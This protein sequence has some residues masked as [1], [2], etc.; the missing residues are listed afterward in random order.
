MQFRELLKRKGLLGKKLWIAEI[1]W[2]QR[3]LITACFQVLEK[4]FE[5]REW[6][7]TETIFN[8]LEKFVFVPFSW[9]SYLLFLLYEP[10]NFLVCQS[11]PGKLSKELVVS[12]ALYHCLVF[13]SSTFSQKLPDFD[14]DNFPHFRALLKQKEQPGRKSWTAEV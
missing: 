14:Q 3:T 1:L 12:S 10:L 11:V 6:P 5:Y 2:W 9:V 13:L 7:W 8:F 4:N